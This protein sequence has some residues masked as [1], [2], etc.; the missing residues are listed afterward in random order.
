M[1]RELDTAE[2]HRI[3]RTAGAQLSSDSRKRRQIPHFAEASTK[4]ARYAG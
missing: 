3:P 1:T 2:K 4:M